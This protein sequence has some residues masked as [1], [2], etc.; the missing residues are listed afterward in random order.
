MGV[1]GFVFD[2]ATKTCVDIDRALNISIG[3]ARY[4]QN[5]D[6]R[7]SMFECL[8]NPNKGL[9]QKELLEVCRAAIRDH[10]DEDSAKDVHWNHIYWVYQAVKLA[11]SSP[12]GTFFLATENS[13][14]SDVDIIEKDDYNVVEF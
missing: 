14:P 5:A 6:C 4:D 12:D 8:T 13:S 1:D 11:L 10:L 7:S 3:A 9:T 2:K